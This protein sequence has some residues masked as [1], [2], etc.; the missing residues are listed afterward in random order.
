MRAGGWRKV[1]FAS[2]RQT[3]GAKAVAL[4]ALAVAPW[5]ICFWAVEASASSLLLGLAC[6]AASVL[7]LL[8]LA[9]TLRPLDQVAARVRESDS[10]DDM[11]TIVRGVAQLTDRVDGLQHRWFGKHPI[12]GLPTRESLVAAIARD[13]KRGTASTCVGAIRFADYDRLSTF[14]PATADAALKRFARPLAQVDRDCFAIW[15]EGVEVDHAATELRA[16]CYALGAEITVGEMNLEPEIEVGT[17]LYPEHGTE[18]MA[19]V[20]HALVSLAKPGAAAKAGLTAGNAVHVARQRFALEQDLRHAI[21]REQF[22]MAFQPVVD[23]S[24]GALV[25]AE[26]L[27]RWRHPEAGMVSPAYFIPILEDANLIDEIG[28][29]TLNAACREARRWQRLGLDRLKIAVNLSATQLRDPG[30]KLMVQRTLERHQLAP[31]VLELELTETA[32]TE[33]AERT[34][35]LFGELRKLG[36]SLA[37]DDF[38]SGYSSLSYLKNLPFDK[39]KIDREFVVD[40]HL[41][42]ESQAICRSLIELTRGLG[43]QILAEGVESRQE[44]EMLVRSGCTI[45]QGFY[46]SE[47]VSSE[48]FVKR[49]LDPAWRN[50]LSPATFAQQADGRKSA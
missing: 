13:L 7:S 20:N 22:E 32:A 5:P 43:L 6:A 46:F 47:P 18:A 23:V 37:I 38:G 31:Q 34:F 15:F 27:L 8:V 25:G 40:V 28:R 19:L 26:A 12:T 21:A 48:Q 50:L 30:L 29:W 2:A 10:G 17:A 42:K 35:A 33:D 49:A 41:R 24:K 16:I 14:D 45:F 36:V 44:V 11:E 39:L 3:I 1:L 4:A 9:R